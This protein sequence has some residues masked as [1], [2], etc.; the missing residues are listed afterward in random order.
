MKLKQAREWQQSW[1]KMCGTGRRMTESTPTEAETGRRTAGL[2]MA[3]A[4][5][6][7]LSMEETFRAELLIVAAF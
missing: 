7:E 6:A 3:V 4:W 1:Q 2:F 5:T